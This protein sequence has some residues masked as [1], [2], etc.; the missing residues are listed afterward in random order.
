MYKATS[1]FADDD[2]IFTIDP[3]IVEAE[4]AR[5]IAPGAP[6]VRF[7]G[8]EARPSAAKMHRRHGDPPSKKVKIS[9]GE[10]P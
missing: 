7:A 10:T 8:S 3:D 9:A 1:Y 5:A 6:V 4:S 2:T